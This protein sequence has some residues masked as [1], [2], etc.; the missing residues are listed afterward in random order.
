MAIN[1]FQ[2]SLRRLFAFYRDIQT[3]IRLK[4]LAEETGERCGLIRKEYE[5]PDGD[6][7]KDTVSGDKKTEE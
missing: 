2:L 1:T 3:D 6:E 4:K 7:A 5:E